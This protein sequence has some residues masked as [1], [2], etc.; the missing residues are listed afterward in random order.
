MIILTVANQ[1]GGVGKTTT[2]LNL[3]AALAVEGL[4]VL[5]VDLDFQAN[6]TAALLGP[7]VRPEPNMAHVLVGA[8]TLADILQ[9]TQRKGVTL[10]PATN[11]LSQ[12]DLQ[13]V[14]MIGRERRLAKALEPHH[15]DFDIAIV[16][17]SPY[18]GLLTVNGLAAATHVLVPVSPEFFSM[19]GLQ[20]LGETINEL[21]TQM[22]APLEVTGYL[23]TQYDARF[24]LAKEVIAQLDSRF[25]RTL[26]KTRIRTNTNLKA[27]PANRMDI[28]EYERST[29][30]PRRG[31][32]DH[33]QL[34]KELMKRL[35][36]KAPRRS[37]AAA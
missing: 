5:L 7:G 17:T 26:L 30:R 16:D 12:A 31:T 23:L 8:S 9:P 20:L 15:A 33:H 28:L 36:L 22:R 32:E 10:A 3:A 24:A 35:A 1:K 21:R 6:A 18:L 11:A 37:S 19:L 14:G 4:R 29:P 25:G 27:A 13:L 34:A 2:V